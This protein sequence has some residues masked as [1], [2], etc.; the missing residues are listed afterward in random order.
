MVAETNNNALLQFAMR[1]NLG[2]CVFFGVKQSGVAE[3]YLRT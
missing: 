1:S 2:D 3:Q